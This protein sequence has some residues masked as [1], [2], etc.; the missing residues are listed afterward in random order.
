MTEKEQLAIAI[1]AL[2]D[3]IDPI[4][5]MGRLA[6][7][8]GSKLDG[9]VAVMLKNDPNHGRELARQALCEMGIYKRR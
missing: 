4:A 3:I 9:H 6:Q 7:K 2:R 8:D 5:R 1:Q